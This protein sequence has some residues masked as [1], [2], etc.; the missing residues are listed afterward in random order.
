MGRKPCCDKIGL[1]KGRWTEEED[2]ILVNFIQVHG[3]GSWRWSQIASQLAGRTDNDIKNYW[4]SHLS[5]RID[6]YPQVNRGRITEVEKVESS[7]KNSE[8]DN[9][10]AQTTTK[11]KKKKSVAGK[12]INPHHSFKYSNN[13]EE[14]SLI[15]IPDDDINAESEFSNL[16]DEVFCSSC[17]IE[18][19]NCSFST[20]I[21][22][23]TEHLSIESN[24]T[25]S[26]YSCTTESSTS[27][28]AIANVQC[29]PD[30]SSVFRE[31]ENL[32]DIKET[33]AELEN[34]SYMIGDLK[35]D[36]FINT[37]SIQEAEGLYGNLASPADFLWDMDLWYT[38]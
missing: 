22:E 10:K 20:N 27:K 19:L 11:K 23:N 26:E 35:D 15:P 14:C 38:L 13:E 36:S 6:S 31:I 2:E 25:T 33:D 4:N 3:Q 28:D 24:R 5:R 21:F 7:Q 8:K 34:N 12:I 30:L 37:V 17:D 32:L 1:K 9:K 18:A 16:C 29:S